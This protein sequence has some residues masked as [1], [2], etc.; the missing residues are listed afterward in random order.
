MNL[1]EV[2]R[3]VQELHD[4]VRRQ[5]ILLLLST[6]VMIGFCIWGLVASYFAVQ[7]VG[8]ALAAVWFASTQIPWLRKRGP[9]E[10]ADMGSSTGIDYC[11]TA[12]ELRQ[13]QLRQPWRWFL[14][15]VLLGIASFLIVPVAEVLRNP[16]MA[17]K[18]APFLIMMVVWVVF[19]FRQV[20]RD[21]RQIQ[22]DIDELNALSRG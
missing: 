9:A 11:R 21:L 20:S 1:D 4:K 16:G 2:R 19:F 18:M 10:A 5:R 6:L 13:R 17:P 22:R 7:R 14:G 3:K 12:L 8:F 15:P